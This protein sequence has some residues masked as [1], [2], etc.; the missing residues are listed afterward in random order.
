MCSIDLDTE[1]S[2]PVFKGSGIEIAH[3]GY[4]P[5]AGVA[6]FGLDC[7]GHC[8]AI[9]KMQPGLVNQTQPATWLLSEDAQRL[10]PAWKIP[11]DFATNLTVIWLVRTDCLHLRA[12]A[13][14]AARS[15]TDLEDDTSPTLMTPT[16]DSALLSLLQA[17]PGITMDHMHN[18]ASG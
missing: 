11:S 8:R 6:H 2:V 17:Q 3:E 1:A 12:F 4:I 10:E 7:A 5:I 9:L 13:Q 18:E 15:H 16:P 14:A